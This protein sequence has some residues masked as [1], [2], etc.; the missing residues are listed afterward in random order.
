MAAERQPRSFSRKPTFRDIRTRPGDNLSR[1]DP[2]C[3]F[4]R[5]RRARKNRAF[6][7][8]RYEKKNEARVQ[9]FLLGARGVRPSVDPHSRESLGPYAIG[10]IGP[11]RHESAHDVR[12]NFF[13]LRTDPDEFA[14]I[15]SK[16]PGPGARRHERRDEVPVSRDRIRRTDRS[17]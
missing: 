5:S 17:R 11:R 3:S 7:E 6:I 4:C 2:C 10:L 14:T 8:I 13:N 1:R 9:D 12:H 16:L 15:T